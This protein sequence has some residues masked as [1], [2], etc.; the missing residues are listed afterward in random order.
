MNE[1]G[2]VYPTRGPTKTLTFLMQPYD[3]LTLIIRIL[4]I[5][6]SRTV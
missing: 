2:P 3:F 6:K 5:Y 1:M 4:N